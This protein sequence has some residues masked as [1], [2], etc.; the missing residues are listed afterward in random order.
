MMSN[1]R[2]EI[3]TEKISTEKITEISNN[4]FIGREGRARAKE[5]C[6]PVMSELAGGK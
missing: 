3:M 1:G 5:Q 2:M 4:N 6:E